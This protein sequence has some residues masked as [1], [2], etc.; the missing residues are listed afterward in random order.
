[1]L[2]FARTNNSAASVHW[3]C[4]DAENFPI[5]SAS[6][7]A[8]FSSLAVQWCENIGAVFL[9]IERVLRRG[10]TVSLSTLG[11]ATLSELRA[12]WSAVDERVHVNRFAERAVIEKAL[13]RSGLTIVSWR[14]E[15]RVLRYRELRELTRELKDIGAHN[16][17]ANRPGG[18]TSR[19]R[20]QRFS[21]A[22]DAQRDAE[23][24]L[25]AT[26]EIWYLQLAKR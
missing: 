10:G 13:R 24:W 15:I 20:L 11:P 21:A 14:E 23:G 25:P 17:N 6:I 18:L 8:I 9:E 1:M 19:A 2:N 26:Y 12:A 4:G 5:A 22:C 7:D 3:L 16:V